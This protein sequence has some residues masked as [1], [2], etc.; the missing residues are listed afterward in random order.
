MDCACKR[1]CSLGVK[2]LS[3]EILCGIAESFAVAL[4][5][6]SGNNYLV[7]LV[8]AVVERNYYAV[9][10]FNLLGNHTNVGNVEILNTIGY[11]D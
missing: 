5:T 2:L 8:V 3:L 9:L 1:C 11:C 7:E 6:H 10:C 4:H